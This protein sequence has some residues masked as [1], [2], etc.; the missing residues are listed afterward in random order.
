M[1]QTIHIY[2]IYKFVWKRGGREMLSAARSDVC[3]M[4]KEMCA[5][6]GTMCFRMPGRMCGRRSLLL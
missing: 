2:L 5:M 4:G 6:C 1:S 3:K